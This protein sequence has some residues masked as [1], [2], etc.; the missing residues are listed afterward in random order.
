MVKSRSLKHPIYALV[1]ILPLYLFR[2]HIHVFS[3]LWFHFQ[4]E[5]TGIARY[6]LFGSSLLL[7]CLED[8]ELVFIALT[9]H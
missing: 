5:L 3:P 8:W 1:I 9:L 7:L 6:A 4:L 2:N